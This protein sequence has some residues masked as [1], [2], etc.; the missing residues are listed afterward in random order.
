[1]VYIRAAVEGRLDEAVARRLAADAGMDVANVYRTDGR[2]NLISRLPGYAAAARRDPW[3]VLCDLDQDECAPTLVAAAVQ[4]PPELFC[5]RVAVRSIESWLLA[6]PGLAARL[7]VSTTRL[8]REPDSERY[9]KRTMIRIARRSRNRDI[10]VG[11]GGSPGTADT[12][13]LYNVILGEFVE[14]EWEP[15]RAAARSPSLGRAIGAVERLA[16]A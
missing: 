16:S 15:R 1:M 10:R 13:I 3:L 2:A 7:E 12:P 6:D 8:P 11:V 4:N 5:F 9:P 14:S